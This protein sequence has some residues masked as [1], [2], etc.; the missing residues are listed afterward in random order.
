M[1]SGVYIIR[2]K[3]TGR[4]YIGSSKRSIENRFS[5][6]LA[7]LRKG[8]H[9][10]IKMQEDWRKYGQTSFEFSIVLICRPDQARLEEQKILNQGGRL[11]NQHKQASSPKGMKYSK[12]VRLKMS[13][14]AKER[15]ARPD[16]KELLR[17][18][19]KKQHRSGNLGRQTW[20]AAAEQHFALGIKAR[21]E[22]HSEVAKL[23]WRDPLIREKISTARWTTKRRKE[24]AERIRQ[25]NLKRA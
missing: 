17:E 3:P 24:Q 9:T 18:R 6:H 4:R 20:S 1:S 25:L 12:E 23:M 5:N 22:K 13:E 16:H 19:A 15:N 2:C 21:A 14:K 10:S 8:A 11:Y 7:L